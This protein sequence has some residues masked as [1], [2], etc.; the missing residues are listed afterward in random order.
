MGLPA[1]IRDHEAADGPRLHGSNRG[2]ALL[3]LSH[4]A[5]GCI[6]LVCIAWTYPE[7]H[8]FF[9]KKTLPAAVATVAAFAVLTVGATLPQILLN[10]PFTT[11]MLTY[12]GAVLFLL[13][14]VMP[15]GIPEQK[16]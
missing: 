8:I 2:V 1:D 12:G 9:R 4:V 10:V 16:L 11:A 14:Y 3:I 7:Y 5:L 15:R 13:W 6:S